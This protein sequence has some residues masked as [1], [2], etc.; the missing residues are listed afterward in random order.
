MR[1]AASVA[2]AVAAVLVS[3]QGA[4]GSPGRAAAARDDPHGEFFYR[5]AVATVR[6]GQTVRFV[7]VGK[8]TT[9]ADT[10]SRGRLRSKLI[11]PRPL[12]HGDVQTVR[13]AKPGVVHYVCT[14]HQTLMR[15]KVVVVA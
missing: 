10:D 5:P 7:N 8:S 3:T 12:G 13:F 14:F 4:P 11:E 9:V 6:V 15:G 1:R 2:V